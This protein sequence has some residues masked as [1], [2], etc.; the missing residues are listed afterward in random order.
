MTKNFYIVTSFLL[1]LFLTSSLWQQRMFL[2]IQ[3]NLYTLE[4]FPPWL[5]CSSILSL[6]SSLCLLR[7]YQAKGYRFTFLAATI[8]TLVNLCLSVVFYII[9]VSRELESYYIPLLLFS[10]AT[11]MVYAM[12]LFFSPAGQRVWL[13]LAGGYMFLLGL[14]LLTSILWHELTQELERKATLEQMAQWLSMAGSLIPLPFIFNFVS[15]LKQ[16][17]GDQVQTS[18]HKV[19][20]SLA[21]VVGLIAF[22]VMVVYGQK[23]AQESYGLVA[24]LNRG[25]ERAL[26]LAQPFEARSY[27]SKAGDTLRYRFMTPLDYDPTKKYPLVI[28][29]HGG[30]GWGTD[31]VLQIEGSWMAQLLSE[32]NNREHYQAFLFVPQCPPRYSWGGIPSHPAIANL[33][34]EA[35]EALEQEFAIDPQRRYVMGESLGGYGT[36]HF[37]TTRPQLFA[38][39]IPICGMGDPALAARIA[40]LPVWALHGEQDRNVPVRGSREMI[41]AIK[42]AGGAPHYTEFA[43]AGHIISSQVYETPGLL[44]WLFAQKRE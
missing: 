15:E 39:A 10:L 8:A 28:C 44:D 17:K 42:K 6:L 40:Q 36:W 20:I 27:V 19:V 16:V 14:L 31:N 26:Q 38:A 18:V 24:W 23:I 32:P 11:G 12:S 1:A 9:V 34:F 7:Y 21:G 22:G 29:L 25:P 3:G 30:G 41:E 33:V 4:A 13:K 35:M 37:I 2:Q 5:L 43:G